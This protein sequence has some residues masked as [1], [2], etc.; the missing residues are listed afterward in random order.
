MVKMKTNMPIIMTIAGSDSGGGAGIQADLKTI[1]THLCYGVSVITCITAQNTMGVQA[2]EPVGQRLIKEQLKSLLSDFKI[3]AIKVGMLYSEEIIEAI[4]LELQN[5]HHSI[6][7][8]LDP[9]MV[10][11]S[12]DSLIQDNAIDKMMTKL[13]PYCELIT[14]NYYEAEVLAQTKILNLNDV[15]LACLKIAKLGAK[16]ILIKTGDLQ[17]GDD[18]TDMLY[19]S[20]LNSFH[21]FTKA[22]I[23]SN[24][25]HGTGCT[26]SSAIAAN[27]GLGFPLVKSIELAKEFT[28]S[29]LYAAR[30]QQL[31]KGKGPVDHIYKWREK[32]LKD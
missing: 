27:R 7:L 17:L 29:A 4:A 9:V 21:Y 6:P 24:N 23:E 15:K 5:Y 10:A 12:K 31:G 14:P 20:E 30:D 8:I 16:N 11:T 26:L 22:K 3:S 18:V 2:I 28:H 13:F 1:T 25:T 19:Q 32:C